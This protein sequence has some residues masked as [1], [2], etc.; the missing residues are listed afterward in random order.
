M[1]AEHLQLLRATD[2]GFSLMYY[3]KTKM[4]KPESLITLLA[5]QRSTLIYT[6]KA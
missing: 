2:Y 1:C 3:E 6:N 5:D 4:A